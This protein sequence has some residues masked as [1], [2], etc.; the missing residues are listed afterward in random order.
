MDDIDMESSSFDSDT[1]SIY[2]ESLTTMDDVVIR[3]D[4]NLVASINLISPYTYEHDV[5]DETV[6]ISETKDWLSLVERNLLVGSHPNEYTSEL[7]PTPISEASLDVVVATHQVPS[8]L[9]WQQVTS[10]PFW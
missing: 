8:S 6:S 7:E 5:I 10:P 2:E 9:A 1:S 3:R 4:L